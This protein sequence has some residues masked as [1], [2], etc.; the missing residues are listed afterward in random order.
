MQHETSLHCQELPCR[1]ALQHALQHA[2]GAL[3]ELAVGAS[4]DCRGRLR[5]SAGFD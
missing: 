4:V 3:S 2:S 5:P 1:H